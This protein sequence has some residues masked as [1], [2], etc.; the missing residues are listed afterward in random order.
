V[1]DAKLGRNCDLPGS[2]LT[3]ISQD[4][5][6]IESLSVFVDPERPSTTTFSWTFLEITEAVTVVLGSNKKVKIEQKI[7]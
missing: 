7:S 3:G 6:P 1:F 5:F 4:K 2:I